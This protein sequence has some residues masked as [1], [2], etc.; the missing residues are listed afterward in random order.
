MIP[1]SRHVSMMAGIARALAV[2]C[3]VVLAG[4]AGG[5]LPDELAGYA[6]DPD[7]PYPD[8]ELTVAVDPGETDRPFDPLVHEALSYWER[9][10]DR[11][12]DF[13][14]NFTLAP[15][16]TDPDLRVTF[17]RSLDRCGEVE[18]AAGCA[19]RITS[20]PQAAD[21][22][23]VRILDDL[24]NE[25]TTQVLKHELGHTLGLDHS[26]EPTQLMRS[27]ASLTML[28][29]PNAS[30]RVLPWADSTLAVFADLDAVP[31]DERAAVREQI[32]HALD[33]YDHGAAGRVPDNV[34]FERVSSFENADVVIYF[35]DGPPCGDGS[36]S[37]GSVYG[38]DPDGD[39]AIERYTRVDVALSDVDTDAT[40]W[41]VA[42]HLALGFGFEPG[43]GAAYP[44]ALRKST[45]DEERRSDWWE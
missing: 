17:Q 36:G 37:C 18:T 39:G 26:D 5:A 15:N 22:V 45:S 24:S 28:P 2:V 33:Y 29:E 19:P 23:D 3:L 13:G 12:L 10:D 41:H 31:A 21:T 4:C 16:A 32:D 30:E 20:P 14:V 25:S 27:R 6:G 38:T 11:Y 35:Q 8:D 1:A 42:R 40:G 43:D 34:S 9:N 7:N 44:P